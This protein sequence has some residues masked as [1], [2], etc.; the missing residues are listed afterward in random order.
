MEITRSTVAT[1][2]GPGEWF[3]G[4]VE[5]V[6]VLPHERELCV[7]PLTVPHIAVGARLPCPQS[8]L[9]RGLHDFGQE[10]RDAPSARAIAPRPRLR[11]GDGLL[12]TRDGI[13]GDD[14][15]ASETL[16]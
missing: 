2:A 14:P 11:V 9:K 15:R 10:S 8:I 6:M 12:G 1:T 3:T 13:R 5:E 16:A 4:A 7:T